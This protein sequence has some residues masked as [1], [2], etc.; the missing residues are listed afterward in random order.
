MPPEWKRTPSPWSP[1]RSSGRAGERDALRFS[2]V[3]VIL[4]VWCLPWAQGS[5][6][7]VWFFSRLPKP[8]R[9]QAEC[10]YAFNKPAITFRQGKGVMNSQELQPCC[11]DV[12]PD[13]SS[14]S[15]V[16]LKKIHDLFG[17]QFPQLSTESHFN[18]CA[19]ALPWGYTEM[20]RVF[21]APNMSLCSPDHHPCRSHILDSTARGEPRAAKP[22]QQMSIAESQ[23]PSPNAGF[24]EHGL[25]QH[26]TPCCP[27]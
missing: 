22:G 26:S 4:R 16:T 21:E 18:S 27:G 14:I 1:L 12:K 5:W 7:Y 6:T 11:L 20:P 3:T 23:L 24:W 10:C 8:F 15:W 19:M 17:P 13:S 25:P 9:W 2:G